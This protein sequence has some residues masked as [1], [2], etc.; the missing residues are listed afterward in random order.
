MGGEQGTKGG[1]TPRG[2][3]HQA[4]EV[5]GGGGGQGTGRMARAGGRD[6][7]GQGQGRRRPQTHAHPTTPRAHL[8]GPPAQTLTRPQPLHPITQAHGRCWA[9]MLC[10]RTSLFRTSPPTSRQTIYGASKE[11]QCAV[12][13]PALAPSTTRTKHQAPARTS[14]PPPPPPPPPPSPPPPQA[15]QPESLTARAV[16][17]Q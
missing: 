17:T 5:G 13:T 6:I 9:R 1:T 15:S 16:P 8:S 14:P 2:A 3:G 11:A 10:G 7:T 4:G 12:P